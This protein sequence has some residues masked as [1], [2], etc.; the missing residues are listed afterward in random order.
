[1]KT[2]SVDI[3]KAQKLTRDRLV[4]ARDVLKQLGYDE[5]AVRIVK[6]SRKAVYDVQECVGCDK[7]IFIC[8]YK[9]IEFESFATPKVNEEKCVGCGACQLVCPHH[10]IQ[11]KGFE[12]ENVVDRYGDSACKVE[13]Q[14]PGSSSSS[15]CLSMVRLLSLR[16][17]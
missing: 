13:S 6:F 10:A 17:P 12:F 4:L 2:R 16:Q 11:V 14:K 5:N 9:A 3:K 15:F 1:M 8:P 7:C